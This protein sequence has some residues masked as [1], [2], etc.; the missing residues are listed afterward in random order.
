M[1]EVGKKSGS[2]KAATKKTAAHKKGD[3]PD[4]A[5]HVTK[6]GFTKK[7]HT[8]KGEQADVQG[9]VVAR[10]THAKGADLS[11]HVR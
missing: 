11:N 6:K 8:K 4:V 1:A 7:S 5:G 10:N 2:K 3:Q 9:H